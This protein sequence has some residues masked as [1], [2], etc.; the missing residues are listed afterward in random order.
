MM[1]KAWRQDRVLGNR[2]INRVK[3]SM[4]ESSASEGSIQLEGRGDPCGLK[5]G[6]NPRRLK[7]QQQDLQLKCGQEFYCLDSFLYLYKTQSQGR[8]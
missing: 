1:G 7:E 5:D 3:I 8:K 6:G 4:L 2:G